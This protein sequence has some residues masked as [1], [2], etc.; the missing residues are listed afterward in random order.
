MAPEWKQ[1]MG[2]LLYLMQ[3]QNVPLLVWETSTM[4]PRRFISATTSRP[5]GVRPRVVSALWVEEWQMALSYM[6]L[7]VI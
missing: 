4:T 2:A 7:R 6:W 5:K 3:S 1:M